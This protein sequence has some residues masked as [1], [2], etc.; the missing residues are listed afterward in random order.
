MGTAI[1][2]F[3]IRLALVYCCLLSIIVG[4]Y[5]S[6]GALA[7]FGEAIRL[8]FRS[9]GFPLFDFIVFFIQFI[10]L[11]MPLLFLTLILGGIFGLKHLVFNLSWLVPTK[12]EV[13]VFL[14]VLPI[15]MFVTCM[16]VLGTVGSGTMANVT[17]AAM[18]LS[19]IC[20]WPAALVLA[21]KSHFGKK[22]RE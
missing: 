19:A 2:R 7:E 17:I 1:L 10:I 5:F 18:L 11:G 16:L 6:P 21:L 22:A 15:L 20:G 3:S 8:G 12:S 13:A 9:V 4:V 14:M